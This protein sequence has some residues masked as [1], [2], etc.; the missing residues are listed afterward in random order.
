MSKFSNCLHHYIRYMSNCLYLSVPTCTMHFTV[1][2]HRFDTSS[3][4]RREGWTSLDSSSD[5]RRQTRFIS[6]LD[7][8]LLL[9]NL[10][11][12]TTSVNSFLLKST[13]IS[14]K[15]T[16][17]FIVVVIGITYHFP[18]YALQYNLL[19]KDTAQCHWN[20]RS[21]ALLTRIS[22]KSSNRKFSVSWDQ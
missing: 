13:R 6:E 7:S 5:K 19:V 17:Y 11:T 14:S 15:I 20:L 3:Q 16:R 10:A 1:H 8:L 12:L 9:A 18:Q 21:Q 4:L 2:K 22:S